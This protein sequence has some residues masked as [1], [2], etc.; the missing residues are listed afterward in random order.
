MA[1]INSKIDICNLALSFLGHKPITSIDPP[2][3]NAAKTCNQHYDNARRELLRQHVWNFAVKRDSLAALTTTPVFGF[4][5]EYQLP[6]DFLR[7]VELN[8]VDTVF[9]RWGVG[10]EAE[11][12][13][14][15][16][17]EDG[18]ILAD[19]AGPLEIR[20]IYDNTD[21]SKYDPMFIKVLALLL[22]VNMGYEIEA[23]G[24]LRENLRAEYTSELA[25]A[26]SVDGQERPPKLVKRSKW[27][28]ERMRTA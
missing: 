22:A 21:V 7:L 6:V 15:Y 10:F 28:R 25:K 8:N 3:E 18:K 13:E 19:E 17:I 14:G 26:R 20:Y 11:E 16:T 4:D 1:A 24:T 9:Y 2:V 27:L 23:N 12:Q 5:T